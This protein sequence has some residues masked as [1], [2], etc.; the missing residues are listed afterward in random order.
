MTMKSDDVIVIQVYKQLPL[1]LALQPDDSDG[2]E[3]C[4][5]VIYADSGRTN[6]RCCCQ[7]PRSTVQAHPRATAGND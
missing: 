1:V 2:D 3:E 7:L 6:H 5:D 4:N